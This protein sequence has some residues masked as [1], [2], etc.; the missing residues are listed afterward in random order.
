[1]LPTEASRAAAAVFLSYASQDAEEA[2][3]ICEA[4]RAAGIEVWFDREELRGGTRGTAASESRFTSVGCLYRLSRR[5]PKH[6]SRVTSGV[7]EGSRST[8]HMTSS[9]R[10]A[11][12]MPVVLDSTSEVKADVPDAFRHV[13]LD[14]PAGRRHAY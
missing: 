10:I 2:S 12:L 4:L 5:T 8:G 1:M 3:R 7:N 9:E 13:Q 11:F 6:E 14:A